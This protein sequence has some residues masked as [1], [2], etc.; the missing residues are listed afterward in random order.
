VTA[1]AWAGSAV[2]CNPVRSTTS[3]VWQ[4]GWWSGPSL[5]GNI[6]LD[7]SFA[8]VVIKDPFLW[9]GDDSVSAW[10]MLFNK[11]D[12][13]YGQV[14]Y[15]KYTDGKHFDFVETNNSD[16][17]WHY[18]RHTFTGEP[19]GSNPQYKTVYDIGNGSFYYYANGTQI[20]SY[21][22]PSYNG[23][24]AAESGEIHNLDDQMPGV[25]SGHEIFSSVE[26]RHD[27]TEGWFFSNSWQNYADNYPNSNDWGHSSSGNPLSEFDIWDTCN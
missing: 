11:S 25:S 26:M 4:D 24:W 7:G 18:V 19:L 20:S 2:A 17:N 13:G 27:N 12:G 5:D 9:S 22:A 8:W 14:G 1:L 23:C 6:C 16:T 15:L 3:G 21:Q 10:S